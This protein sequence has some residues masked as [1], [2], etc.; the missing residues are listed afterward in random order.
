MTGKRELNLISACH[1]WLQKKEEE[2]SDTDY[3]IKRK[4]TIQVN[5]SLPSLIKEEKTPK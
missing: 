5:L 1:H 3:R 2:S 4:D